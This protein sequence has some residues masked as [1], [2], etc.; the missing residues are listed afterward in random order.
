MYSAWTK[1][2][3]FRLETSRHDGRSTTRIGAPSKCPGR[4]LTYRQK[5]RG[6]APEKNKAIQ[7]EVKKLVDARIMKHD[8]SW[9]MCVDFKDL[10]KAYTQDGYPLPEIDWKVESL[11]GYP[12]KCFLDAYKKYH[13]IKMIGHS[14]SRSDVTW[15]YMHKEERFPMDSGSRSSLQ[16]DEE[17]HSGTPN[18]DRT[19]GKGGLNHI[20]SRG[21]GSYQRNFNDRKGRQAIASVLCEP[22]PMRA[23]DQLHPYGKIGI[24]LVQRKQTAEKVLPGT[25]NCC[26][27]GSADKAI[28]V[29]IRDQREDAKVEIG[30]RRI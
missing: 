10:N 6:Q 18:A 21:Q 28:I 4:V 19:K 30:A 27:Y 14:K 3:R 22:C 1:L 16:I 26:N 25:Y 11:C 20:P 12:F 17:T 24:S 2:K 13:Q 29:K 15:K 23:G 7:E 8:G 9:R 5:K